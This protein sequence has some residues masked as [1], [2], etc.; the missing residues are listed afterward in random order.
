MNGYVIEYGK[1]QKVFVEE[2]LYIAALECLKSLGHRVQIAQWVDHLDDAEVNVLDAKSFGYIIE[3]VSDGNLGEAKRVFVPAD[4]LEDVT[5][6]MY[7]EGYKPILSRW[8]N[9]ILNPAADFSQKISEEVCTTY[10]AASDEQV[11]TLKSLCKDLMDK[12]KTQEDFV[13]QISMKTENFKYITASACSA[14]CDNLKEII[15]HYGE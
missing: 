13:Q 9:C 7:N 2:G 4:E 15:A 12:D 3:Y 8:T 11:A 1:A 14:L 10:G 5:E 6:K